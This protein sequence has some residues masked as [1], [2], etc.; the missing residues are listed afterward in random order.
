MRNASKKDT[1][2]HEIL[3]FYSKIKGIVT[4][5]WPKIGSPM[6]KGISYEI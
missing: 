2:I 3:F 6:L 1:N 4:P 5:F